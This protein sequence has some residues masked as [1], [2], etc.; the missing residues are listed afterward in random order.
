MFGECASGFIGDGAVGVVLVGGEG[1]NSEDIGSISVG[2]AREELSDGD[3][4]FGVFCCV[5]ENNGSGGE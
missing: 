2:E 5:S 1:L 4:V 3:G